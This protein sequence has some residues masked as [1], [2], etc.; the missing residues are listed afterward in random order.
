[1]EK[2][3]WRDR[4]RLKRNKEQ[5]KQKEINERPKHKKS[6]EQAR[7][8]KMSRAQDGILK[9]MHK[10]MEVCKAQGFMY[11]IIPDKGKPQSKCLQDKMTAEESATWLSV[12]NQEEQMAQQQNGSGDNIDASA[13]NNANNLILHAATEFAVEGLEDNSP[14]GLSHSDK[15]QDA[16][17]D[18]FDPFNGNRLAYSIPQGGSQGGGEDDIVGTGYDKLSLR[19]SRWHGKE[20]RVQGYVYPRAAAVY[21]SI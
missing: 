4:L 16:E 5:Q 11:D 20:M 19:C 1:M 8:K 12:L 18:D 6:Q 7:R 10:M 9:Y 2:R 17:T 3:M 14:Q 15:G 21:V 13:T